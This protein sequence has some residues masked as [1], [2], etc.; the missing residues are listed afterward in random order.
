MTELP[1]PKGKITELVEQ[2]CQHYEKGLGGEG[3]PVH[4]DT[5]HLRYL[6]HTGQQLDVEL[7]YVSMCSPTGFPFHR[8]NTTMRLDGERITKLQLNYY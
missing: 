8:I 6:L 4:Q 3:D 2:A 5:E 7:S 1:I